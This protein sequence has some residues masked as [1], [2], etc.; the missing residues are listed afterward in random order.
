MILLLIFAPASII[1]WYKY[2]SILVIIKLIANDLWLIMDTSNKIS[3]TL[4]G[5]GKHLEIVPIP[6]D[7][8]CL[9]GSLLHQLFGMD[10]EGDFYQEAIKNLRRLVVL[11]IRKNKTRFIPCFCP[12]DGRNS[13]D[14]FERS[15]ISLENGELWGGEETIVAVSEIFH[16]EVVVVQNFAVL[17]YGNAQENGNN[18]IWIYYH[19]HD[20]FGAGDGNRNHYDSITGCYNLEGVI[21]YSLKVPKQE[22]RTVVQSIS[23]DTGEK[24]NLFFFE[25]TPDAHFLAMRHQLRASTLLPLGLQAKVLQYE[26]ELFLERNS[27][28]ISNNVAS[29]E[30]N[31]MDLQNWKFCFAA[32]NFLNKKLLIT[33]MRGD[34]IMEFAPSTSRVT[35]SKCIWLC[36]NEAVSKLGSVVR[37]RK[38]FTIQELR[39]DEN[40]SRITENFQDE[41]INSPDVDKDNMFRMASWNVR[42]CCRE[43]KRNDIDKKLEDHNI[44]M[45]FLQ[46]V[47]TVCNT[48]VT[49]NFR[50]QILKAV[51]NKQRGLAVLTRKS[52]GIY[53]QGID[54]ISNNVMKVEVSIGSG[55]SRKHFTVINV[56]APN[57]GIANFFA[58]LGYALL[59]C[60]NKNE[61][62]ICGDF[63][64][65]LGITDLCPDERELIGKFAGHDRANENGVQMKFFMRT[66]K[67]A[68][69]NTMAHESLKTT[70]I[71]HGKSSQIDH[72]LLSLNSSLFIKKMRGYLIEDIKTD[73]KLLAFGVQIR[74]KA[75]KSNKN[76][77]NVTIRNNTESTI[78]WDVAL[79]QNETFR[80]KYQENLSKMTINMEDDSV[81][82]SELWDRL[83]GKLKKAATESIN[84]LSRIPSSPKRRLALANVKKCMF[85]RNRCP[86]SLRRLKDLS[87][88]Q[89][90][91]RKL[92]EEYDEKA[93][94][95]FF[96]N[97]KDFKPAERIKRTYRYVKKYKKKTSA[98]KV[99]DISLNQFIE[100]ESINLLPQE[101]DTD[102]VNEE[103]TSIETPDT[104]HIDTIIKSCKNGKAAGVD[105]IQI[106]LLKYADE[107]TLEEFKI[108]LKKVWEKNSI[109]SGWRKTLVI[110]IPKIK[111]PKTAK[112][113]RKIV[114]ASTGYKIYA[115]WVLGH[116]VGN[117][118][119]IG[120][121]QAG[122]L[123]QRSTMD[124]IFAA[125]RILEEKWNAG[126][127]L[128][129]MALDIQKAFDNI[130][131]TA[132]PD[133]LIGKGAS[134][135]LTNRIISC[136]NLEEQQILWRGQKTAPKYRTKGVKQGC[137]LS[138]YVFDLIMEEVLVTVEDELNGLFTLNQT[139]KLKFPIV[140]VYADDILIIART[141]EELNKLLPVLQNYLG[142]VNLKL[143]EQKCQVMV[144]SPLGTAPSEIT[145]AGHVF[146]TTPSLFYLGVPI[147]ERLH[148]KL[149]TRKRSRDAVIASRIILEF[150]KKRKP[151]VKLG[152]ILYETVIA[153][154][155]VYGTQATVLTKRSRKSLRRY[156]KQIYGQ[157]KALCNPEIGTTS[158]DEP[159]SI[160]NWIRILQ[161]RYWGHIVRRP[162]N[163]LLKL[164]AEYRLPYKKR[165]RPAFTWWDTIAQNMWRFENMT[166]ED[167][168]D[169]VEN[170]EVFEKTIQELHN[171]PESA[172]EDE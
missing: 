71:C 133:I 11:H 67:L 13:D 64:S 105:G 152:T 53:V 12:E 63:N 47:N 4:Q 1:Y 91:Y 70:W 32:S 158:S 33:N 23:S 17:R 88:A 169:I 62:L 127:D 19:E 75:S 69:R 172:S 109:P 60:A 147:T 160:T 68:A 144:R 137:P 95:E 123:S 111:N 39:T 31:G 156:H 170:K 77:K 103:V 34:K 51:G 56:H 7:G 125:R 57:N 54:R 49:D 100:P 118:N 135:D 157:I 141:V 38:R 165:G 20:R 52:A 167:W 58:E 14:F 122:F 120:S 55:N 76:H 132:L 166:V 119:P 65:Q 104:F 16:V 21:T 121:H 9:F 41:E 27:E 79:L 84:K 134:R 85:W 138:P 112:D 164:A 80:K 94:M 153:P 131:L 161:L 145:I 155:M 35:L 42:G 129:V 61:V 102:S 108:L 48:I 130:S 86:L 113:F 142:E 83:A 107:P 72:V 171:L 154:T 45:A 116:L 10:T 36:Y 92:C 139:G 5:V 106:E 25:E 22:W 97:L 96:K 6:G 93:E 151:S 87:E 50:W 99:L 136:L 81:S 98:Q 90:N 8:G 143:N 115:S 46:E 44:H 15:L 43:D 37:T 148:R 168:Y 110:P 24:L 140:L 30:L 66:H 18:E 146:K 73:H 149:T 2:S 59:S 82:T 128:I 159:K 163:H 26:C 124:H 74:G 89:R 114:L 29:V 101:L 28:S 150:L 78:N 126:D 117:T 162:E 40:D 3:L